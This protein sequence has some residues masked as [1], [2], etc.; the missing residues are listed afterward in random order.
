MLVCQ[1]A[2]N[3]SLHKSILTDP[4]RHPRG[5]FSLL[6]PLFET[7]VRAHLIAMDD[8]EAIKQMLNDQFRTKFFTH[9]G[10]VDDHFQMGGMFKRVYV[11]D[12]ITMRMHSAVHMGGA[13]MMRHLKIGCLR[14]SQASK[15]RPAAMNGLREWW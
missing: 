9:P 5:A 15:C 12:L 14:V 1:W 13:Q 11:Y 7:L 3:A 10:K 6:R 8:S 4:R 2:M